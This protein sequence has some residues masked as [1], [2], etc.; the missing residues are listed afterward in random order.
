MVS[1]VQYLHPPCNSPW[2]YQALSQKCNEHFGGWQ[3][4]WYV[5]SVIVANANCYIEINKCF[6]AMPPIKS[7]CKFKNGIFKISSTGAKVKVQP[8][9][10]YEYKSFMVVFLVAFWGY[11]ALT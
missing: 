6:A 8:L 4:Y 5:S 7:V 11:V 2:P 9:I 1:K 3:M 10:G